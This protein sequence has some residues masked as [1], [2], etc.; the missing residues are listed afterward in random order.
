M[1]DP[2]DKVIIAALQDDFPVNSHPYL[3]I[4]SKIGIS[5]DELLKRIQGYQ[6][7]GYIRKIGAVLR[8][9]EVGFSTNV[10]CVWQVPEEQIEDIGRKFAAHPAVSHCYARPVFPEWQHNIYTM[11]HG[12][13]PTECE[14]YIKELEQVSGLNE[15]ILLFSVRELKKSSMRYFVEETV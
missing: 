5:E 2:L 14:T 7:L 13:S 11:L 3:E 1:I 10:L 12:R 8:H 9:R 15:Y 6:D 4:A